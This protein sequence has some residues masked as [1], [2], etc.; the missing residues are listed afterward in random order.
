MEVVLEADD[1][2]AVEVANAVL[3]RECFKFF[4]GELR[5]SFRCPLG[6][7]CQLNLTRLS[8]KD[9]GEELGAIRVLEVLERRSVDVD[10]VLV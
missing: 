6:T 1:E 9:A 8:E 2:G 3:L 4:L 5:P 10:A 7:A